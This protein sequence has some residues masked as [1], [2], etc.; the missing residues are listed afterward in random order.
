MARLARVVAAGVPHHLTQRGNRSQQVFFGDEDFAL[1]KSLLAEGCRAAGTEV[2][3]YCLMPNHVH[4]I[5]VPPDEDGL[6]ATLGEAHRR[7]TLHI[8]SRENWRGYLWQG[9]F[10]SFPMDEAYLMA[11]ARHVELNP[12][13]AR[14]VRRARDWKWSSARAH[15][16]R[17]D[18]GLVRVK[19][20]L[21]L[22]PQWAGFLGEGLA[23]EALEAIRRSE[24]TGRPLGAASFLKRLERRL[25]RT[26]TKQKPGPKPKG[27]RGQSKHG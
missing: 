24:R 22:A 21:A 14:L 13:R 20:L 18:D 25:G 19:P 9:R 5:L 12:V 17:K 1:Y 15:L 8:N 6:R 16:A 7:Y 10:A 2:W 4:L 23:E 11:A 26:L 27:R 3:A